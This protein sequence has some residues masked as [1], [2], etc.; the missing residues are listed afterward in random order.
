MIY[1]S[2]SWY[3]NGK[4]KLFKGVNVCVGSFTLKNLAYFVY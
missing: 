3:Y 1:V 2:I 4:A